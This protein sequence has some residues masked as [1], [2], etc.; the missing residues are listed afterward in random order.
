MKL[1]L[2]NPAEKQARGR[3]DFPEFRSPPLGLAYVAALTPPDWEELSSCPLGAV[4]I[5]GTQA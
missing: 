2:I 4:T 3:S 1:L 5:R